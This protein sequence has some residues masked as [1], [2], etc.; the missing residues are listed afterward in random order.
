MSHGVQLP[1]SE[2]IDHVAMHK[3]RWTENLASNEQQAHEELSVDIMSIVENS[4][5]MCLELLEP[6]FY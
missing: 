5:M 3:L 6:K 4:D 1:D 2:M